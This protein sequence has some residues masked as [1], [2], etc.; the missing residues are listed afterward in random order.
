MR[1]C[2]GCGKTLK[3]GKFCPDCRPHKELKIKDISI[4][5]CVESKRFFFK[6]KWH[7]FNDIEEALATVLMDAL[8]RKAE[9]S[10]DV[11]EIKYNPGLKYEIQAEIDIDGDF[12]LV[13]IEIQMTYSEIYSKKQGEY[14]E[15]ILQLRNVDDEILDYVEEY[16]KK[17]IVFVN[18][19]K[20]R[21]DGYD[22]KV[23]D[24]KIEQNLGNMLIKKF[25]GEIK[26]SAQIHTRDRQTSKDVYRV[27]VLYR[28]PEYKKGDVIR[29]EDR[30]LKI[31]T[32]GKN[33]YVENLVSRKRN[34]FDPK[35]KEIFVLKPKK[36]QVS[37]IR[38]NLEVLDPE[39]YESV[40]VLNL[41]DVSHGE[42]IKIVNDKGKYFIL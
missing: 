29:F 3:T 17:N 10:F 28:A 16:L 26:V 24:K 32:I 25:G 4:K 23:T 34:Y 37:R 8:K 30:Y 31:I 38:P 1:F 18:E 36:T 40:N 27:N 5:I 41:K 14:F 33:L 35:N 6:N 21:K 15:G 19:K 2:P 12:Y 22:L 20:K 7:K 42:N 39:T 13:P 11:P 9:M